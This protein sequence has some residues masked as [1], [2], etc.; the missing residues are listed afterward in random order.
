MF[1]AP[2]H[3]NV[4]AMLLT[5][6]TQAFAQAFPQGFANRFNAFLLDPKDGPIA[7]IFYFF[8]IIEYHSI[9]FRYTWNLLNYVK[10]RMN[11]R[12]FRTNTSA[13]H[14]EIIVFNE[15]SWK[16]IFCNKLSNANF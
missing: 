11:R 1:T 4:K 6:E 7:I 12:L 5:A 2:W 3:R 9:S 8:I 15:P 10:S 16:P 13:L 14:L